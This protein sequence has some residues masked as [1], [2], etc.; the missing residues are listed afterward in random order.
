MFLGRNKGLKS[1]RVVSY[2]DFFRRGY[3]QLIS[4]NKKKKLC[5]I[6]CARFFSS[7][8]AGVGHRYCYVRRQSLIVHYI[9]QWIGVGQK[10]KP[11]PHHCFMSELLQH[12]GAPV[13]APT[14]TPIIWPMQ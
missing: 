14:L 13:L 4:L 5:F 9:G 6:N 11:E 12:D 10:P 8:R 2:I 3:S 7:V 1:C